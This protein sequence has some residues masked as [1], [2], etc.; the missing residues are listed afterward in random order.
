MAVKNWDECFRLVIR[1]EGGY[2]NHKDD[3]GG[4]TNLGVTRRAWEAYT[5]HPASEE[6]MR[7]LTPLRVKT[8]Y[9]TQY[10]DKV[11]GDNLPLG[12]DYVVYDFAVNSGVARASRMIQ[13]LAGV[14]AD[15]VIGPKSLAAIGSLPPPDL[16]RSLCATR[17]AFL[18]S[19]PTWRVFGKGWGRRVNEV[20]AKALA[21]AKTPVS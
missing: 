13:T 20:E 12:L 15:G 8:F 6:D 2:V 9:K 11:R 14:E 1:H 5:G 16:I 7:A 18:K 19:L 3:P 4:M 17:L 21:M 10:W